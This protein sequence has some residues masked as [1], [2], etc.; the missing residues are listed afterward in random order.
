[1]HRHL[2]ASKYYFNELKFECRGPGLCS[3]QP[4][5]LPGRLFGRSLS[6]PNLSL[7]VWLLVVVGHLQNVS[8]FQEGFSHM[9]E[10]Q[11]CTI[12]VD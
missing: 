9:M 7:A 3:P 12:K 8:L 2:C 11:I 6:Q 1:M 10:I 5:K 4:Q